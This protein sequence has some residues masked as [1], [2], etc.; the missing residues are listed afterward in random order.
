MFLLHLPVVSG[1][2]SCLPLSTDRHISQISPE[3]DQLFRQQMDQR[4]MKTVK[5]VLSNFQ[6]IKF[7]IIERQIKA[8]NVDN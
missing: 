4:S 3:S 2:D 5:A 1:Y 7:I 8:A 6:N